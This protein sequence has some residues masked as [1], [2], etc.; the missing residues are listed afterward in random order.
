MQKFRTTLNT[1]L[2]VALVLGL[3]LVVVGEDRGDRPSSVKPT[4]TNMQPDQNQGAE[5]GFDKA[6]RA[7]RLAEMLAEKV[8]ATENVPHPSSTKQRNIGDDCSE[9]IVLNLGSGN[10]PYHDYDQ[11]TCGRGNN[12]DN[13]C[14]GNW[15]GGEDIIY[16]LNLPA[17]I[18]LNILFDPKGDVYTGIM[19]ASECP[20][21][22]GTTCIVK[23]TRVGS[24]PHGMYNL[25]LTAGT[26][27]IMIDTWPPPSCISSFDLTIEEY[28][29]TPGDDCS[30]PVVVILPGD[31]T[32]G[33]NNDSYIDT[34]H[35]CG[36]GND[37]DNTCLEEEYD[38]DGGEDI[39]YRLD[40][41]ETITVDVFL[42]P[43]TTNW[44]GILIDDNCPPDET[45]CIQYSTIGTGAHGVYDLTL[46]PGTY[47]VMVDTWPFPDCIPSFTLTIRS[48][49]DRMENDAWEDCLAV[50]DVDDLPF[51]TKEATPDGPGGC[52]T[53]PTLWYCYT[54]TC[55][56]RATISLCGSS[57]NTKL[58]VWDGTDPYYDP[59]LGCND[60]EL[61]IDVVLGNTYLVGVGGW[62][63]HTGDG[64]L[65]ISCLDNDDCENVTPVTLTDGVPVTFTGDN[66]TATHEC[67]L[68]GGAHTWHAF[69]LDTTMNVTLDYCTTD[70]AFGNCWLNL[71]LG[72]PCSSITGSGEYNYDD[73]SDGNITI[74]WD[75]LGTGTYYYPVLLDTGVAEGPYTLHVVGEA[76][77]V[78]CDASGGCDN[79]YISRVIVGDIDNSSGCDN[80][81]DYTNLSTTMEAGL[82]YPIT[83]ELGNG[84]A[85]DIGA[86][87]VDWNQDTVF[88]YSEEVTLDVNT[89]SGPYTGHVDPPIN[90]R[91]GPTRMRVR[92]NYNSYPPPCGVTTY[93]EVEDYTIIVEG[94]GCCELRGDVDHSGA[95][96][97]V[98]LTYLVEFLF[99]DG[100]APPCEEEGN[101]DGTGGIN[102]AD[103]TYL[104]EFLFF[105]G[106]A[107]PPC[108]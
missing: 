21:V 69:T 108:F 46:E 79:E 51:S 12:Y 90:A 60:S 44:S 34:N 38:Y 81:G 98:D 83:I 19:I 17:N 20:D 93:G 3:C 64:I 32:E 102:V 74:T 96:N 95:I 50:G 40:V 31:M 66:S 86:A 105:D 41:E 7:V 52:L 65:N 91:N 87:W 14:L 92:L 37:Y 8:A 39:M 24:D 68:F 62:G 47:Y 100:P 22:G 75:A 72:C 85:G 6:E 58:G 94:G 76:V 36:R 97:V 53:S 103:L 27:Y 54:A 2:A 107:P 16:E 10:L 18:A 101:V 45:G 4:T 9:P 49:E 56:G 99:F 26:Y 11:T 57:Y 55:T 89:G 88:D 28:V 23:S 61:K 33:S 84:I 59:M 77:A 1:F 80:Y 43:G 29:Q 13:T 35:T 73:C 15:D 78:Y 5:Q 42:D 104:V 106:P 67:D 71:A 82:S 70:P 25:S 63:D 48:V 30:E